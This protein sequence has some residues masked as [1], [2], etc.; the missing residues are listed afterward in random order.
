MSIKA[1]GWHEYFM[2]FID[3]YAKFGYIYFSLPQSKCTDKFNE[4]KAKNKETT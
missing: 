3:D 4:F 1:R 2:T